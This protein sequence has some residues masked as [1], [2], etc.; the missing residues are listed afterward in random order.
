MNPSI[1]HSQMSIAR[2]NGIEIAYDTFGGREFE[3][4]LLIMGLSSQMILWED[5]FCRML[6]EK[7]LYVIRFDNRDVGMSTRMRAFGMPHIQ[8]MLMGKPVPVPYTLMD[9]ADDAFGLLD[10]LDIERAHVVGASMGG[11]VGQEM[12]ISSP[13]RVKTLTSIMSTTGNPSLPMPGKEAMEILF[14]PIPTEKNAFV[15]YFRDVWRILSG[16]RYTIDDLTAARLGSKRI[17]GGSIRREAPGSLQ[18][19]L[20]RAAGKRGLHP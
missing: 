17:S 10:A 12:A 3:P 8:A 20:P 11:M 2:V 5:E 19:S 18:R 4:V 14:R 6:A 16:S 1:P 9:M 13:E 7:G 15:T